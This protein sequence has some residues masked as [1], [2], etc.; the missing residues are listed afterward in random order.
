MDDQKSA[1]VVP[2][3]L[4]AVTLQDGEQVAQMKA[5]VAAAFEK[6]RTIAAGKASGSYEIAQTN[7]MKAVEG[8]RKL[9]ASERE[10]QKKNG[11]LMPRELVIRDVNL[12]AES[13]RLMRESMVRR[14][15]ELCPGLSEEQ[16][17]RVAEAIGRVREQE[18]KIFR[19]LRSLNAPADVVELIAA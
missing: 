8:L 14:V 1:P 9:E 10:W 13:L 7:F 16:Q 6:M 4:M 5:A 11:Q 12:A 18:E 15:L 3:D 19:D 2:F 17:A